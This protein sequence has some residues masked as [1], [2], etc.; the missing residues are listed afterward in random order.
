[1]DKYLDQRKK[2]FRLARAYVPPQPY[3]RQFPLD[4]ALIKGTLFTCLYFPWR[5]NHRD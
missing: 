3:C 4:V 5:K 1:M 2:E